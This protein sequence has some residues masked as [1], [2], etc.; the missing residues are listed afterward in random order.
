LLLAG[1]GKAG[2]TSLFWHLS[3]HPDICSS[4]VKEPR[5]FLPLSEHDVD[6]GDV[7]AIADYAALFDRCRSERYAMEATPHYF[8]GGRRLI[9]GIKSTLPDPHIVLTLRDP[10]ERVWSVYRFAKGNMQLPPEMTFEEYLLA[11]ERSHRDGER[12]PST[13][14]AYWS[15][16]G[17]VYADFLPAW[18]QSFGDDRL[19]IVFFDRFAA[20]PAATIRDL[21]VWLGIDTGPV[22]SFDFSVE[23]RSTGYRIRILHRV[24]L[25]ANAEHLLRNRRRLKEPL[26][27]VYQSLNGRRH[28]EPMPPAVRHRLEE[29]FASSNAVVAETLSERGYRDLPSWLLTPGTAEPR[30]EAR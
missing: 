19:R 7:P 15:I 26:R 3:Q 21:C 12:R 13:G 28:A 22:D 4:R 6:L 18:L 24:A 20:D 1:V 29:L 25:A 5:Y 17:S 30:R 14:R 27:R 9:D 8:H 11:C 23:N 10:V 16:R 2:T